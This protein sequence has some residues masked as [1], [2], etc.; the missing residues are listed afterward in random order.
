MKTT[1]TLRSA[2]SRT[3]TKARCLALAF[4][5]TLVPLSPCLRAQEFEAASIRPPTPTPSQCKGGPGT[6]DPT[7]LTCE[8]F[9]L[10]YL[11]MMAYNLRAFQLQAP[12]WMGST[13]FNVQATVPP[14]ATPQQ[15]RAMLQD[16]L[17][18]RFKLAVHHDQKEMDGY[19]LVVSKPSVNLKRS[20]DDTP[21]ADESIWRPPVSGPPVRVKAQINGRNW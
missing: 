13:R 21:I 6:S 19:D 5:L 1:A 16:L 11:V 17:A 12:D 3:F 14:G 15:F 20:D 8:N 2:N 9:S 10:S 7:R 4:I 18:R